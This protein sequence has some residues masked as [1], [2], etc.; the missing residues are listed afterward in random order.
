[1]VC[2]CSQL[3]LSIQNGDATS[4]AHPTWPRATST[5]TSSRLDVNP[6]TKNQEPFHPTALLSRIDGIEYRYFP[7][8]GRGL[9][10]PASDGLDPSR[11]HTVRITILAPAGEHSSGIRFQGLWMNDGANLLPMDDVS[12]QHKHHDVP[13][14]QSSQSN[15]TALIETDLTTQTQAAL[16]VENRNNRRMGST[17]DLPKTFEVV[18]DILLG[19]SFENDTQSWTSGMGWEESVG[20]LFEARHVTIAMPGVCLTSTCS[21]RAEQ[22][23]TIQEAYFRRHV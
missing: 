9:L 10:V 16:L 5:Q 3:F 23:A 15:A 20:D 21:H 14:P 17:S 11:N 22:P 4:K 18:T 1:M 12:L 8:A 13:E 19:H 2:N 7:K 6:L